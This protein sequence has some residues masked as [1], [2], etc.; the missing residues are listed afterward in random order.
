MGIHACTVGVSK[1]PRI[2]SMIRSMLIITMSFF[3]DKRSVVLKTE[4]PVKVSNATIIF[5]LFARSARIPPNGERIIVGIVAMDR[6][7]ANMAAEPV[8]S[9]TYIDNESFKI[10]FPNKDVSCP[11][12]SSIKFLVNS[13]CVIT[14]FL[15]FLKY[16]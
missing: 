9:S 14:R 8:I 3:A 5:R 4:M 15:L 10:K 7:P 12:I 1:A 16:Q 6:I 13:F 11:K 2:E